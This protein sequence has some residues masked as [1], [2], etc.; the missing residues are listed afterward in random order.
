MQLLLSAMAIEL[1]PASLAT[2]TSTKMYAE[3]VPSAVLYVLFI[4]LSEKSLFVCVTF[5]RSH[6]PVVSLH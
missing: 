1:L 6:S 3:F 2:E 5:V 4:W